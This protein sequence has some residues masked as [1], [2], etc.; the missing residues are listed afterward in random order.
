V[1]PLYAGGGG[2]WSDT[3][4]FEIQWGVPQQI[5]LVSPTNG[6][7][8]PGDVEYVWATDGVAT[9]YELWINRNGQTWYHQWEYTG[10][11]PGPAE[12]SRTVSGHT[13]ATY[14]W[15][16]RA[17]SPDGTGPWSAAGH[18]EVVAD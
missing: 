2:A 4:G 3:A 6:N 5:R 9:D 16:V 15:W 10:L 11:V 17:S 8:S 18:F 7:E 14:A 13:A 12:I 1:K